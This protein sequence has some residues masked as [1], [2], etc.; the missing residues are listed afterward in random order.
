VHRLAF[1]IQ[2]LL[3]SYHHS[4]RLL[5]NRRAGEHA[6]AAFDELLAHAAR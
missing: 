2:G 6:R 5:R 3:L 1:S 4:H